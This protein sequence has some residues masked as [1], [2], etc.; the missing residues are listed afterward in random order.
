MAKVQWSE[1]L[2]VNIQEIDLQHRQLVA[3]IAELETALAEGHG[4]DVLGGVIKELNAYV[5]EHF[6][7]E[8]RLMRKYGFPGLPAH[9]AQHEAFIEKLLHVELD[10]LGGKA[11]L[12]EDLFDYLMDWLKVHVTGFDQL[13]ASYFLERGLV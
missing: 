7:T 3:L 10:Y 12:P 8:E 1:E 9:A 4:K 5:R 11:D 2:S 13:Y 6:T